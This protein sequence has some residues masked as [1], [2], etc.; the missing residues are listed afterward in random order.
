MVLLKI[1]EQPCMNKIVT[2]EQATMLSEQLKHKGKT[3]VLV[4]GCFDILHIGHIEFLERARKAGDA[5]VVL[6]ENDAT[7]KRHK[8]PNRPINTQGDRSRILAALE[9]V[10][11]VVPLP[12][13]TT[14]SGYDQVIFSLKPD[15]IA[16]TSGDP[17]RSHK[18]RQAKT[19]GIQ[20]LDVIHRLK[21]QSTT[22]VAQLMNEL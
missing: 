22:K 16:T 7:I 3:V 21:D 13:V 15:I 18:E 11:Y 12:E 9:A 6:V 20:V 5:L 4:G 2:V 1:P 10:S 19:L 17:A 14:D 8:G